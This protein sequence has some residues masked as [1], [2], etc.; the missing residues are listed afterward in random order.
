MPLLGAHMSIAGGIDKSP[1]RAREATCD[2]IQIFT[3]SNVQWAAPPI[4]KGQRE[5]FLAELK[6]HGIQRAFAHSCYLINLCSLDATTRRRSRDALAE[7][8]RRCA[9]LRLPWLVMHPGSHGGKGE[10]QGIEQI[11]LAAEW[12]LAKTAHIRP[13]PMLL[14]ETTSG[15][16]NSIGGRFENLA[17][18]IDRLKKTRRV[19]VCFDTCHVF[20]AGYDIRTPEAYSKT[21]EEFDRIVGV[22]RIKAFHLNDSLGKLGSRLDRHEHIGKGKIGL[23]GFRALVNDPRF[24]DHPMVLETPKGDGPANDIANLKRLRR[25]VRR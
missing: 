11:V 5:G 9:L 15:Q 24:A 20:A 7:E 22:H 16:R 23:C 8:L 1:E 14:F 10:K 19:G 4:D 13:K 2:A 25:L 12:A 3:K 17:E 21:L 6:R 18:I